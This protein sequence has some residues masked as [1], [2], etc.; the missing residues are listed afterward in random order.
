MQIKY[1]AVIAVCMLLGGYLIQD[2]IEKER[3]RRLPDPVRTD[4]K[5]VVVEDEIDWFQVQA[6][7]QNAVLDA[8]K[9]ALQDAKKELDLWHRQR[10][11]EIEDDFLDWY[12]G[13]W[14]TQKRSIGAAWTSMWDSKEEAEREIFET[15]QDELMARGLAPSDI[16]RAITKAAE[17]TGTVFGKELK[18][19][20]ENVRIKFS[21]PTTE[22]VDFLDEV[23]LRPTVNTQTLADTKFADLTMKALYAGGGVLAL[24]GLSKAMASAASKKAAASAALASSKGLAGKAALA[25]AGKAGTLAGAKAGSALGGPVVFGLVVGGLGLVEWWWHSSYVDEEKPRMRKHISDSLHQFEENLLRSDGA[26]GSVIE[27]IEQQ[28]HK[29]ITTGIAKIS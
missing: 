9:I 7:T 15:T 10:M 2:F 24:N 27:E 8:K 16:D 5:T 13:W 23:A 21:I 18:N 20:F 3:A 19:R 28:M 1:I 29:D 11:R 6:A 12:F 22:W 14:G 25:T 17:K 26:I 4:E